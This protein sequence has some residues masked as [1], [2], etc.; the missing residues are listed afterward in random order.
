MYYDKL[1]FLYSVTRTTE[2]HNK[3][4]KSS[5]SKKEDTSVEYFLEQQIDIED[6]VGVES[7]PDEPKFETDFEF[8]NLPQKITS[9]E[10]Q[11]IDIPAAVLSQEAICH[12]SS[13]ARSNDTVL[14]H[15]I[16]DQNIEKTTNNTD[17]DKMF[18]LSLLEPLK[19][20]PEHLK[21]GTKIE[22]MKVIQNA[23]EQTMYMNDGRQ[24]EVEYTSENGKRISSTTLLSDH[25]ETHEDM[26]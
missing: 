20:V 16:P 19:N 14:I 6:N 15:N 9:P 18:L 26:P 2:R 24:I 1:S 13:S 21:L 5:D 11:I 17:S 23:Q 8:I 3:S 4:S 25:F 22:L 12:Q 7:N 10:K